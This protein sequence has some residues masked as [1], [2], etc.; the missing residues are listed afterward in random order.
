MST[1]KHICWSLSASAALNMLLMRRPLFIPSQAADC[2]PLTVDF[3]LS[4][5]KPALIHFIHLKHACSISPTSTLIPLINE[6]ANQEGVSS[7]SSLSRPAGGTGTW[8]QCVGCGSNTQRIF[9]SGCKRIFFT[10]I[11]DCKKQKKQS[12]AS[13]HLMMSSRAKANRSMMGQSE[14]TSRDFMPL[15]AYIYTQHIYYT[16]RYWIKCAQVIVV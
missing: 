13:V 7:S 10:L 6:W 2:C 5:H 4:P 15:S 14:E 16:D 11:P 1:P 9:I 3:R 12:A 8:T